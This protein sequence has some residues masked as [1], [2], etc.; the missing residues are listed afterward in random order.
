VTRR[1]P[2]TAA[3]SPPD[4][5]ASER[6]SGLLSTAAGVAAFLVLL[7]FAV[8]LLFNLYATSA[9]TAAAYDAARL[10]AARGGDVD[11]IPAAEAHARDVLGRYA[12]RV[13]FDWDG[14]DGS[15]VR[16]HVRAANPNRLFASLPL[17]AIQRV[18]RTVKI[19]IECFR[20]VDRCG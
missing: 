4:A 2:A 15:M 1:T 10:V 19:R 20:E 9:V 7:A 11:E 17:D 12:D 16:V 5:D 13:T 18:D 14:T 6:G 3:T 8:Q